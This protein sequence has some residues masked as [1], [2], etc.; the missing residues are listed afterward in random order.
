MNKVRIF[1][2]KIKRRVFKV[3]RRVHVVLCTLYIRF[4]G[5]RNVLLLAP[6]HDNIG[7]HA[8]ALAEMQYFRERGLKLFELSI[9]SFDGNEKLLAKLL[10]RKV[11]VIVHGGGFL[12]A[13]WPREGYRIRKVFEFFKK[14]RIV[15]FPQTVT[16]YDKT[17]EDKAFFEES[18]R[19]YSSNKNITIFVRDERS[20]KFMKENMPEVDVR[21]VPDIVTILKAESTGTIARKNIIFCFRRDLEKALSDEMKAE[22]EACVKN[23]YSDCEIIHTDTVEKYHIG[24]SER[25]REVNKKLSL[26]AESKLVI[27]DR[28]HGMVMS[29]ITNTPCIAFS[30]TNGKVKGVYTWIKNNDYV[31][32]VDTIDQF[33]EALDSLDLDKEYKYAIDNKLFAELDSVIGGINGK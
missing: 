20:Y 18:K 3:F 14:K 11:N 1:L 10:P 13:L 31:K 25:S 6:A 23:K 19:I 27:T 30:N 33:K 28:L 21:I 4:A 7:D 9:K 24:M 16:F 32:Y 8:I 17:E 26:F 22:I 12:G 5:V 2:G 29:A 15:V